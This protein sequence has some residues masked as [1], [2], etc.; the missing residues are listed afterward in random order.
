[1]KQWYSSIMFPAFIFSQMSKTGQ[2]CRDVKLIQPL[3][4]KSS[5]FDWFLFSFEKYQIS[6]A[7]LS[8]FVSVSIQLSNDKIFTL[9]CMPSAKTVW[10]RF[11]HIL[12]FCER[13]NFWLSLFSPTIIFQSVWKRWVCSCEPTDF[14]ILN[15]NSH[16]TKDTFCFSEINATKPVHPSVSKVRYCHLISVNVA[17]GTTDPRVACFH[18][19][20]RF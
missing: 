8:P 16:E 6:F 5:E 7:L 18:Q 2:K 1:M 4:V 20:N 9:K 19:R 15:I 12:R 11:F 13:G 10:L 17:N 3:F 14:R